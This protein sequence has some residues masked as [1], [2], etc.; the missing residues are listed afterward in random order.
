MQQDFIA[1]VIKQC[2]QLK[3]VTKINQIAAVFTEYVDTELTVG[4]LVYFAE[5]ALLGGF[6]TDNLYSCTMPNTAT[7]AYSRSYKAYLSYVVPNADELIEIVNQHFNP[8]QQ[9]VTLANLDIM[10]VNSDGSV[11][12]STGVVKDSQAA[13]SV[14]SQHPA[15]TPVSTEPVDENEM[16]PVAPE[17]T[18]TPEESGG[19][20]GTENPEA[21]ETP[22]ETP[23]PTP[24]PV[25]TPTP[26]GGETSSPPP[27]ES[28]AQPSDQP[29]DQ[30]TQTPAE[31]TP[32]TESAPAESTPADQAPEASSGDD[33]FTLPEGV[34]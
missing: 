6:S 9:D 17:E 23:T 34:T 26:D 14:A 15:D 19:P 8:Y 4:N 12:S 3:N 33:L 11:S 7:T 32:P 25:P 24:E 31:T 30:N 1:A 28:P 21:T 16:E 13:Q 18:G 2:L 27:T 10:S 22:A 20:A 29:A 5:Q